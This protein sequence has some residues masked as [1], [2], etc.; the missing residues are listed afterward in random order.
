[1]FYQLLAPLLLS[2]PN[3]KSKIDIEVVKIEAEPDILVKKEQITKGLI[4]TKN[5]LHKR[6]QEI[7]IATRQFGIFNL[8]SKQQKNKTIFDV[9]KIEPIRNEETEKRRQGKTVDR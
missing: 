8:P 6:N 3:L 7:S 5:T 2:D 9:V 4:R 1:M